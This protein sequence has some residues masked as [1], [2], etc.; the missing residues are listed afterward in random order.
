[1]VS[2][3][4]H[5]VSDKVSCLTADTVSVG[6]YALREG[7]DAASLLAAVRAGHLPPRLADCDSSGEW[8]VASEAD[9]GDI[10]ACEG[11]GR[12]WLSGVPDEIAL[13][14]S[15]WHAHHRRLASEHPD[16]G[17]F[18]PDISAIVEWCVVAEPCPL[19]AE[20]G[21]FMWW[22]SHDAGSATVTA[23][24]WEAVSAWYEMLWEAGVAH[25]NPSRGTSVAVTIM[26]AIVR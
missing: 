25:R 8:R 13:L 24:R 22:A 14:T 5:V 21:Q 9:V 10:S 6:Y 1:M 11:D 4:V 15:E 20:R 26:P 18:V 2:A 17:L 3:A 23:A 12:L 19:A 16:M 7:L